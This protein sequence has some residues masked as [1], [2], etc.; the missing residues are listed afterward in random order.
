VWPWRK[1]KH[2]GYCPE[3][4]T[5]INLSQID[6]YIGKVCILRGKSGRIDVADG[7]MGAELVRTGILRIDTSILHVADIWQRREIK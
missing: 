4:R 5:V 3:I 2:K 7:S 6:Q 1:T